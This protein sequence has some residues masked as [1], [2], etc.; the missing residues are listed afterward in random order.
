MPTVQTSR[1]SPAPETV[2]VERVGRCPECRAFTY[3]VNG[4]TEEEIRRLVLETEGRVLTNLVSRRDGRVMSVDCGHARTSSRGAR[5]AIV[6]LVVVLLLAALG[7]FFV[8]DRSVPPPEDSRPE[9]TPAPPVAV[10]EPEVPFLTPVV[11]EPVAVETLASPLVRETL[12]WP[13]AP[14][15]IQPHDH[16]DPANL[17]VYF[18]NVNSFG[19]GEQVPVNEVLAVLEATKLRFQRCYFDLLGELK[20]YRGAVEV[21]AFVNSSGVSS[22]TVDGA[23]IVPS[24]KDGRAANRLGPPLRQQLPPP[25]KECVKR[26]TESMLLS[27]WGSR[28]V[29]FKLIFNGWK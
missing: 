27:E 19:R 23:L 28:S 10:P 9:L 11:H 16:A 7:A 26:S 8:A 2:A 4:L 17:D 18:A 20:D 13:I 25:L 5:V 15:V 29:S 21:T 14:V 22:C 1:S 24:S 3:D 12:E 6:G